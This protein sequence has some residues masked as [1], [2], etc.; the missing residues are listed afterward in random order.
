MKSIEEGYRI[1]SVLITAPDVLQPEILQYVREINI[2]YMYIEHMRRSALNRP[3][4]KTLSG[5]PQYI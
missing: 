2:Y 3:K 5:I 4:F 1:Q